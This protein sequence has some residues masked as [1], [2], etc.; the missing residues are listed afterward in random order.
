MSVQA[1]ATALEK[2]K[3]GRGVL[4]GGVPGVEPA[5]IVIL[6]G[7]VVGSNAA[8]TAV[9]SGAD[10]IVI[11]RSLDVLRRL[12]VQFGTRIKTV[13]STTEAIEEHVVTADL[14][15]GGVLIPG[16][17]APKLVTRALLKKMRPGAVIVD[18]AIDQGGCFET[19]RP[20]T[21]DDPTYEVDGVVHYCV[22][23]MPG[24]VPVT[25]S[26]ALNN[27]TMPYVVALADHG[28]A[29][30]ARRDPGLR[31]G[32]NVAGGKVTHPAVAEG[33]G[34][35]YVPPEEALGLGQPSGDGAAGADGAGATA[36]QAT[37][38]AH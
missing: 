12:V 20:T 8:L 30:A 37:P 16:A 26:Q 35:E 7:G 31:L 18:V 4:L 38:G 33:V 2:S 28:I 3:G 6:G 9:G 23:N 27:A 25:S 14:V 34:M 36:A 13:Y 22:A 1:G 19:S 15:I 5:K 24:A 32:I 29:E 10:V 21:H 11:D 17:S